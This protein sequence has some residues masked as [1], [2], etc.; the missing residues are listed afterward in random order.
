MEGSLQKKGKYYYVVI[1]NKGED[2]K[3]KTEW[4]NTKCEKK[5]EAEKVKRDI[6]NRKE[7][8]TYIE[9]KNIFFCDF[10]K[11]W[12]EN[13]AKQNCEKTTYEGYKLIFDK[14]IYPYFKDKNILL[15]KLQPL[16]IQKYYNFEIKDGKANGKGGLSPN[17][18]I[19]HHAN[20]HKVLDYAVK[21]Q[22]IV[23]NVADAVNIPKKI[24]FIGKFY[25]AEQI[26]KLLEQTKNT[27]IESATFITCNYGLRR[28]EILGLKWDAIDFEE[29][30]ITICETRVRYNK[31]TIT[32]SPKNNTSYRTLPLIDSVAKFLKQL[33]IKQIEQ[34][35]LFG[36]EYDK[37]GYVC[38]WEEGRPLDTA[39]L[40]HKFLEIVR[41]S[42]LPQIRFH[43]IR[44]STA[45][46]LLKMG[47]TMKEISVW[48]GH[49]D[50]STTMNIYSHVDI[51]MKK[52]AAKKINDLFAN[53]NYN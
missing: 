51:E 52:N 44:H 15:Q 43:D 45:S 22:L 6:I 23:R 42:E 20:I 37:S 39:Y 3:Y 38:C 10:Y 4:I 49:S 14:H 16:D 29:E 2:G 36:K 26:E 48:L 40:S 30:T 32:K 13:Y 24:K 50:I 5:A 28:G 35:L 12:L 53:V 27:P 18:V 17:T 1:S 19:K 31:D 21:M 41:E 11:D 7:N 34:K 33:K 25:S 47:V 8:N 46:Y 9:A